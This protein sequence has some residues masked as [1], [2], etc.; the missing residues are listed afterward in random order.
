[1]SSA[2]QP[3]S[4]FQ[5]LYKQS[6]QYLGGRVAIMLFGFISFP[7]YT[8]IFSVADYG[9]LNLVLKILM[10]V[11]VFAKLGMQTTVVRFYEEVRVLND[12]S[13]LRNFYSTVYNGAAVISAAAAG[14]FL[15]A[16]Y[17]API[18]DSLRRLL[19]TAVVLIFIR[20]LQ[21]VLYAFLRVEGAAK[22]YNVADVG[23]RIG[24]FAANC[25][26]LLFWQRSIFGFLLGL[27]IVEGLVALSLT[28]RLLRR[29]VLATRFDWPLF[30]TI[31]TYGIPLIGYELASTVL[32][33]GDRLLVKQIAGEVA[34]GFF[35]AA[36]GLTTYIED[37]MLVPLNLA[38]MPLCMKI[39]VNRG[40]DATKSF[41]A[42]ALNMYVIASVCV[43]CAVAVTATDLIIVLGSPKL[44]QAGDLIPYCMVGWLLYGSHLFF[45]AGLLIHKKTAT[46][47]SLV[48]GMCALNI[49]LNLALLPSVG[50][51]GAAVS[52]VITYAVFVGTLAF[53]SFKVMPLK[54]ELLVWMRA[55]A[56][57]LAV[58][59]A[60]AR[61][62][63]APGIISLVVKGGVFAILYAAVLLLID[64]DVRALAKKVVAIVLH[65]ERPALGVPHKTPSA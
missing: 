21:S 26:I 24:G 57:G 62:P 55:M 9:L 33:V 2:A 49:I 23:I 12:P 8:R 13:R 44:R 30:R 1:M 17:F 43:A 60:V 4:E 32:D 59:F 27:S 7:F 41:L 40:E 48:G 29:K 58:A 38:L 53:I 47:A 16:L 11:V 45:Q 14:V 64:A 61:I 15:A 65:R 6:A 35:A 22:L 5:A 19:A 20:G 39:W 36:Q 52:R 34:L 46:M 54:L 50:V 42:K 25:L 63:A 10:V 3:R 18:E 37:A 51:T 56:V 28:A 31:A